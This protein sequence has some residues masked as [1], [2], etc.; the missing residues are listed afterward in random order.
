MRQGLSGVKNFLG[1]D[2]SGENVGL[3]LFAL[4]FFFVTRNRLLKSLQVGKNQFG[5]DGFEIVLG[6]D[7]ARNVDDIRVGESADDL[8]DGV[9]LT[10]VGKELV[11]EPF[12]LRR[13]LDDSSDVDERHR[14]GKN[15]FT[16]ENR[17]KDVEPRVGQVDDSDIRLNRGERIVRCE[18]VVTRERIEQCGF[19]HIGESDDTDGKSHSASLGEAQLTVRAVRFA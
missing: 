6:V 15:S 18:N 11:P 14:R 9:R 5:I 16:P 17:C 3:H 1:G 4:D 19:T 10:N 13:T 7:L 8:G 2:G 12:P